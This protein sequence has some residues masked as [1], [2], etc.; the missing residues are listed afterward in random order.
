MALVSLAAHPVLAGKVYVIIT[1]R[2]LAVTVVPSCKLHTVRENC[3]TNGC[4][5][6]VLEVPNRKCLTI[7]QPT[8][9][10]GTKPSSISPSN[11][12]LKIKPLLGR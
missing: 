12:Y 6:K 3:S 8:P 4:G 10:D 1:N 11:T 5:T 9:K 2:L 7:K